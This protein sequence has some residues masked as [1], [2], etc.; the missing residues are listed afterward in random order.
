MAAGEEE[1]PIQERQMG[2]DHHLI[3][4]HHRSQLGPDP[5]WAS[6]IHR[7]RSRALEDLRSRGFRPRRQS[8]EVLRRVK[9]GLSLEADAPGDRERQVSLLHI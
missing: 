6:V 7:D 2:G 5:V 4:V 3:G 1:P 9:L 8:E